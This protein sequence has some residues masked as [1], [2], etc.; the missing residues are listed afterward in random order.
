VVQLKGEIHRYLSKRIP[1]FQFPVVQ[2]KA[3]HAL[4][5][6][7]GGYMFQFPVVQLK[8]FA[9]TIKINVWNVS[10]PCGSIK[11]LQPKRQRSYWISFNSLWFN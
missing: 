7:G 9:N 4:E 3:G 1:E 8:D 11:R 5:S 2:L 10:I 6:E